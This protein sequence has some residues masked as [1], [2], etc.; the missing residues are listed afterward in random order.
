MTIIKVLLL[1]IVAPWCGG[2]TMDCILQIDGFKNWMLFWPKLLILIV[3]KVSCKFEEKKRGRLFW[4]KVLQK[5]HKV[6]QFPGLFDIIFVEVLTSK[7]YFFMHNFWLT[8]IAFIIYMLDHIFVVSISSEFNIKS[9]LIF[10]RLFYS[11]DCRRS[12]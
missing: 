1:I 7:N 8:K 9:L 12:S 5:F 2:S 6:L 11:Y 4:R 3:T 10:W